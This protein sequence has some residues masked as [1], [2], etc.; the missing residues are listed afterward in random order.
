M[1]S[2]S[3]V[4][5]HPTALTL[6]GISVLVLLDFSV[7]FDTVDHN[8]LL[9]PLEN[10]EG[11]PGTALSWFESNLKDRDFFVSIANYMPERKTTT[12]GVPQGSFL[13]LLLFN[14]YMLPLFHIME[15]NKKHYQN[16]AGDTQ[17]G[18]TISPGN[19]Y[20]NVK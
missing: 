4:F 12:C 15:S 3:Q 16:Y 7:A 1:I 5:N 11:L 13:G 9:D 17:I 18:I 19:S 14:I 20:T 8:I 10:L 6:S 2:S